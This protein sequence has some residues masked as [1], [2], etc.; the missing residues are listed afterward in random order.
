MTRREKKSESLD[1]RLPYQQKQDFMAATRQNGETASQALRRFIADYVED[2]RLAEQTTPVQEI[3]MTLARHRFK[4]LAT[5]AGAALGVFSIAALPSAADPNAFDALD[6]NKDGVLTE[7][8]IA[9]GYDAVII[10]ALDTDGSGGV[11]QDELEAAGNRVAVEHTECD[12]TADCG[13]STKSTVR[14]LRF[15]ESEDGVIHGSVTT[16]ID[17]KIVVKRLDSGSELSEAE[18]ESLIEEALSEAEIGMDIDLDFDTDT[19][20]EETDEDGSVRVMIK[21]LKKTETDITSEDESDQ[22]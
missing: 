1:I 15:S 21:R 12:D 17:R 3:S 8:E 2:A 14:I 19:V 11:S 18:L 20:F 4:T 10:E 6:K 5:A 22:D 7:G 16:E 13:N 9:P